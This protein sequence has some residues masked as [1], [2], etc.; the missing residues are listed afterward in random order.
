MRNALDRPEIYGCKLEGGDRCNEIFV[1][2]GQDAPLPPVSAGGRIFWLDERNGALDVRGCELDSAGERCNLAE[3]GLEPRRRSFLRRNDA[4]LAWT[5]PGMRAG[6]CDVDPASGQCAER[7]PVDNIWAFSRPAA[8]GRLLSWVEVD[9]A[10]RRPLKICE[11]DPETG[12]CPVVHVTD[13]VEDATP[14]MSGNRLVWDTGIADE[15]SDVFFCEFDRVRQR[16]PVQ[17]VTAHHAPQRASVIDGRQL[18]WEDERAGPARI[19]GLLLPELAP[20]RDRRVHSG[21]TLVIPVR[22]VRGPLREDPLALSAEA[23]GEQSLEELGARFVEGRNWGLFLWRPQRQ[24]T[25]THAFTFKGTTPNGLVTRQ[26]VRVDVVAKPTES[27]SH[28]R[29][30]RLPLGRGP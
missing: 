19:H 16:C 10:G 25:G 28:R 17:R 29:W 12:A 30:R 26:T 1:S 9:F 4:T 2:D 8:S 3:T 11:I 7:S 6:V 15:A 14:V 24:H 22:R 21:R 20:L 5:E 23:V 18:V 13:G 27:R